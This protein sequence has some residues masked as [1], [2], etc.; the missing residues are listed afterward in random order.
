MSLMSASEK[1][2]H[3][4]TKNGQNLR[5]ADTTVGDLNIDEI[6]GP[7]LRLKLLVVHV[8]DGVLVL[9]HPSFEAVV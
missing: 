6:L 3:V 9:A 4:D 5:S 8:S 7:W 1:S 2:Y